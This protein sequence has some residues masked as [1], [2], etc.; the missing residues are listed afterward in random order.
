MVRSLPTQMLA[1]ALYKTHTSLFK[2]QHYSLAKIVSQLHKSPFSHIVPGFYRNNLSGT[3][4]DFSLF[5]HVATFWIISVLAFLTWHSD[6]EIDGPRD[7]PADGGKA[8]LLD[9]S[10]HKLADRVGL[11][12]F[13]TCPVSRN[14][15]FFANKLSCIDNVIGWPGNHWRFKI[16]Q[17][18]GS[19]AFSVERCDR[20]ELMSDR[21][22]PFTKCYCFHHNTAVPAVIRTHYYML[23]RQMASVD[24]PEYPSRFFAR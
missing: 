13:G 23:S 17:L 24:F 2:E 21:C 3:A 6:A 22:K 5:T 14:G 10:R 16:K 15:C 7:S 20:F 12:Y 11:P 19:H 4:S 1:N 8:T 18:V 9:A